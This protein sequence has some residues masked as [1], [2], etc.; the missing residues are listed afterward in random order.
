MEAPCVA[1]LRSL[2]AVSVGK[3][4]MQVGV[5][6]E[7]SWGSLLCLHRC[8]TAGPPACNTPDAPAPSVWLWNTLLLLRRSLACC[9]QASTPGWA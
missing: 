3:T 2:G 5:E 7:R 1:A 6:G 8:N 4:Q 9:R